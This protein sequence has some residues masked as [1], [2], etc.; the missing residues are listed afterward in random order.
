MG[1]LSWVSTMAAQTGHAFYEL[2]R[3]DEAYEW[4]EK[5]RKLGAEDDLAT[6][7]HYRR[8]EAKVLARRGET[9]RAEELAR[10][11]VAIVE[12][13]D[14][15]DAQ[16]DAW[17]DLGVVLELI[18]KVDEAAAALEAAAGRFE[19]KENLLMLGRTRARLETLARA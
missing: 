17:L 9:E 5:G 13:T 10:D 12:G 14:M 11:A 1:H 16:G 19:R 18:G 6:Q 2:G 3:D 4:A 7:M 15:L 8:V